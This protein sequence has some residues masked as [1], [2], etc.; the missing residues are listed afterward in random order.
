MKNE[1]WNMSFNGAINKE[2]EGAGVW[3]NPPKL[4]SK[5]FSYKLAFYCTN[6]MVE[7]EALI[8]GLRVLK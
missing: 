6:N 3:I 1:M 2:G 5:L 4:G 7:Y 8:L